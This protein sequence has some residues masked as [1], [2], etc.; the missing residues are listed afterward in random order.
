MLPASLEARL[1]AVAQ[2]PPIPGQLRL[3]LLTTGSLNPVH[4]AHIALGAWAKRQLDARPLGDVTVV[5]FVV[6]PSHFSYVRSK[7]GETAI[8]SHHRLELCRLAI[9]NDAEIAQCGSENFAHVDSWECDANAFVDFPVT[10]A[11]LQERIDSV[12]GVNSGFNVAYLC[13]IDHAINCDLL[14]HGVRAVLRDDRGGSVRVAFPVVVVKRPGISGPPPRQVLSPSTLLIDGQPVAESGGGPAS[15]A[16]A[17]NMSSSKIREA[18]ARGDTAELERSMHVPCVRYMEEHHILGAHAIGAQ[19][20]PALPAAATAAPLHLHQ[21]QLQQRGQDAQVSLVQQQQQKQYQQPQDQIPFT[22]PNVA[23]SSTL[24]PGTLSRQHAAVAG[25]TPVAASSPPHASSSLARADSLGAPQSDGYYPVPDY[26]KLTHEQIRAMRNGAGHDASSIDNASPEIVAP[27]YS[28]G[29]LSDAVYAGDSM[30]PSRR[31][32]S[33]S[34]GTAASA[35]E[36]PS[37]GRAVA[38]KPRSA[39]APADWFEQ[40]FG[41]PEPLHQWTAAQA[42]CLNESNDQHPKSSVYFAI[43]LLFP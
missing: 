24:I 15:N 3:V 8:P 4:K 7:L 31:G 42:R 1:R 38:Q 9:E 21:Q 27:A 18:L 29:I 25:A 10:C 37:A 33:S 40:R 13:G 6:S 12:F 2:Q 23:D 41:A 11:A 22:Q 5:A 17:V 26:S 30:R 43:I 14:R 34:A 19:Q 39:A 36:A 16:D 35:T 20:S 32:N 28:T